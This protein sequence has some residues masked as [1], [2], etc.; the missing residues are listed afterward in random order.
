MLYVQSKIESIGEQD[1]VWTDG[2]PLDY[3]ACGS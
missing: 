1:F 2:T 3:E